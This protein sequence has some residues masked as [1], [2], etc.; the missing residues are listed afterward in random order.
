MNSASKDKNRQLLNTTAALYAESVCAPKLVVTF[1]LSKFDGYQ[2][3]CNEMFRMFWDSPSQCRPHDKITHCNY[4]FQ[5]PASTNSTSIAK[6]V[7]QLGLALSQLPLASMLL[8]IT[9]STLS[10]AR[11]NSASKDKN[12]QLLNTTAALY[13]ESVCA[14]KLV[15]TFSLTA[16]NTTR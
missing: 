8:L 15:V 6:H 4:M 3:M 16:S 12:R 13:A 7:L 1:I 14:P 9:V 11:T 5:L 10:E 2:E